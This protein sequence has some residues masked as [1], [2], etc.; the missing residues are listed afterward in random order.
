MSMKPS[1]DFGETI[2]KASNCVPGCLRIASIVRVKFSRRSCRSS[3]VSA[4]Q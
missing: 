4:A 3:G 2:A 1:S